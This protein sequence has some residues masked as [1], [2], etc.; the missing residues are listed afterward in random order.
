MC[1]VVDSPLPLPASTR[2]SAGSTVAG[3]APTEGLSLLR[4]VSSPDVRSLLSKVATPCRRG[5]APPPVLSEGPEVSASVSAHSVK[6]P[7]ASRHADTPLSL[8]TQ[9]PAIST[10]APVPL[11]SLAWAS[12]SG[13]GVSSV[14][15][16][17][18]IA[19]AIAPPVEVSPGYDLADVTQLCVTLQQA[20]LG[21]QFMVPHPV[22]D[23]LRLH[24]STARNLPRLGSS[25]LDLAALPPASVAHLY[26]DGSRG[27]AGSGWSVVVLFALP[28]GKWHFQG[29]LAAPTSAA[30]FHEHLHTSDEAESAALA[31][32]VSWCISLPEHVSSVIHVDCD[33]ARHF[34]T[35]AWTLP[36]ARHDG[37]CS[38]AVSRAL[39]IFLESLGRAPWIVAVRGHS[40]HPWNE[41]ADVAARAASEATGCA[42]DFCWLDWLKLLR[43]PLL[44][45]LWLLPTGS[46]HYSMPPLMH[47][48][49]QQHYVQP[50][51]PRQACRSL[52]EVY[53][54]NLGEPR[55]VTL[56][57]RFRCSSLNVL[58]LRDTRTEQ[59]RQPVTLLAPAMQELMQDQCDTAELTLVGL[60][61][62]RL[63]KST[64][65]VS[66]KFFVLSAECDSAGQGGCALWVNRHRPYGHAPD[67]APLLLQRKHLFVIMADP[68]LLFV[69]LQAPGLQLLVVVGHGPHSR[70]PEEERL[71][72]WSRLHTL[73][74]SFIKPSERLVL[75]VD[76]NARVGSVQSPSVGPADVF[77]AFCL[78]GNS[79]S[80]VPWANMMVPRLP[81]SHLFSLS[82][83]WIL[84][85]FRWTG[86]S[87]S[88]VPGSIMTLSLDR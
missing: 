34:A 31:A 87:M 55:A 65:F 50:P 43:S 75:L 37:P 9:P 29:I 49:T 68:R 16:P 22:L 30:V 63:P 64:S 18:S 25:I 46:W 35:G 53:R 84:W 15:F 70:R 24:P 61:E 74:A 32:A 4:V 17:I 62:T 48:A 1:I 76:A 27:S 44:P 45:W 13:H 6:P 71:A 42:T 10:S 12:V 88:L 11:A 2:S 40:Q 80:L 39:F 36:P 21:R 79:A 3:P 78:R 66:T 5:P 33:A 56:Q 14:S 47:L 41:L 83:A 20:L 51:R 57:L 81:G 38:A 60:Q 58:T 86:S 28:S 73:T 7:V 23:G 82:H 67:G 52:S 77:T 59:T 26:T 69:R 54:L 19:G 72:W 8:V 85:L